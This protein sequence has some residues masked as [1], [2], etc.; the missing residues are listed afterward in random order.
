MLKCLTIDGVPS[1][2][3]ACLKGGARG[4]F[5]LVGDLLSLWRKFNKQEGY[6]FLP[7]GHI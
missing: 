7:G 3:S 4:R 1:P 5:I 2:K 6:F